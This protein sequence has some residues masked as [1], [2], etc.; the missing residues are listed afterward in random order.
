MSKGYRVKGNTFRAYVKYVAENGMLD[1]VSRQLSPESVALLH[2]LPLPGSW[3]DG[4]ALDEI[5]EAVYE[6]KGG[7]AVIQM[8][9]AVIDREMLPFFIPALRAIMRVLGTSPATL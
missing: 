5:V 7:T 4:V 9:R 1:D 2:T 3:V 8:T 6:L